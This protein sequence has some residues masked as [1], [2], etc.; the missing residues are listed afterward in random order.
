MNIAEML[1]SFIEFS[2]VVLSVFTHL[3]KF[4]LFRKQ[5]LLLM[6]STISMTVQQKGNDEE[7]EEGEQSTE[8]EDRRWC[9]KD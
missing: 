9:H 4:A 2:R 6:V 5:F 7:D 3:L 8:E 1:L